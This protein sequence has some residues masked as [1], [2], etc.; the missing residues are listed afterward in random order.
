MSLYDD[1]DTDD[2][3][4]GWSLGATAKP[5]A[6]QKKTSPTPTEVK[7]EEPAKNNN[8]KTPT[9][10]PAI[11]RE[12]SRIAAAANTAAMKRQAAENAAKQHRS[13]M[14]S[15]STNS[16]V[17]PDIRKVADS[18]ENPLRFNALTGKIERGPPGGGQFPVRKK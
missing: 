5:A 11:A 4:Q 17:V 9:I 14:A 8:S 10:D 1:I 7:K 15:G 6:A 18:S 12:R 3:G 16:V 2:V 13:A